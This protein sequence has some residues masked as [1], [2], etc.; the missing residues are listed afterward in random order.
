MSF[1][2][3]SSFPALRSTEAHIFCATPYHVSSQNLWE[4]VYENND[5]RR[6][7]ETLKA[8]FL[9]AYRA[10]PLPSGVRAFLSRKAS[11]L[12]LSLS[13]PK[14]LKLL[15]L[16][17]VPLRHILSPKCAARPHSAS[18]FYLQMC[19]YTGNLSRD[20]VI[21]RNVSLKDILSKC[22][23]MVYYFVH[24]Y[25]P[26]VHVFLHAPFK[27]QLQFHVHII[28]SVMLGIVCVQSFS[29]N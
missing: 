3:L 9:P 19:K 29:T 23:S 2:P 1:N 11:I 8:R 20:R 13:W 26:R 15:F 5:G 16:E 27:N 4:S 24:N 22:A 6:K 21:S 12:S 14:T 10:F 17:N 28:S 18:E 7:H 25:V